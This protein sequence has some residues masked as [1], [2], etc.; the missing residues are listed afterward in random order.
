[1]ARWKEA[2]ARCPEP[3]GGLGCVQAPWLSGEGLKRSDELKVRASVPPPPPHAGPREPLGG[4]LFCS[5]L[6]V[7]LAAPSQA[8]LAEGS[9][10]SL[11]LR[12][13]PT[14]RSPMPASLW[15]SWQRRMC[16]TSWYPA[17]V[18]GPLPAA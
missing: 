11:W 14:P 3:L 5:G 4:L 15:Q 18:Q 10:L 6:E 12:G 16:P 7:G 17:L 9:L 2:S 8:S 13:P 1:M